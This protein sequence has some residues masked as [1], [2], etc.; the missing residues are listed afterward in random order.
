MIELVWLTV[1]TACLLYGVARIFLIVKYIEG[2]LRLEHGIVE[3]SPC[4]VHYPNVT[5][6]SLSY[7]T[8]SA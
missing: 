3:V 4:S 5:Q 6:T 2:L 1:A 7:R 8:G